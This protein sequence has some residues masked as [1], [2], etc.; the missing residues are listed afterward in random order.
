MNVANPYMISL[1]KRPYDSSYE[2]DM[3]I[4]DKLPYTMDREVCSTEYIRL[5]SGNHIKFYRCQPKEACDIDTQD[6]RFHEIL[7]KHEHI[8][9]MKKRDEIRRHSYYQNIKKLKSINAD[10]EDSNS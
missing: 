9:E 6:D 10:E 1:L 7:A 5:I 4:Y 3:S 8:S 2:C